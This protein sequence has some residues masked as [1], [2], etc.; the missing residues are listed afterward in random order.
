MTA[1]PVQTV[2]Y[3]DVLAKNLPIIMGEEAIARLIGTLPPHPI[4]WLMPAKE[5]VAAGLKVK[6]KDGSF[7]PYVPKWTP[8]AHGDMTNVDYGAYRHQAYIKTEGDRLLVSH[9]LVTIDDGPLMAD[10]FSKP[11]PIMTPVEFKNSEWWVHLS[12]QWRLAMGHGQWAWSLPGGF[13]LQGQSTKASGRVEIKEEFG[14]V[15]VLD[16]LFPEDLGDGSALG[17]YDNRAKTR[18]H[19]QPALFTFKYKGTGAPE[20]NPGDEVIKGRYAIRLR[21]MTQTTD[22]HVNGGVKFAQD[23]ERAGLLQTFIQPAPKN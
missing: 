6:Q 13:A 22:N 14:D 1:K 21:E 5:A 20:I 8:N 11:S 2:K 9:D 15:E 17:L 19:F 4:E 7:L 16:V 18:N 3:L 12:I 10:G 23:C